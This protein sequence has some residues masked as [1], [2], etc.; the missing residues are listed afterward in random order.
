MTPCRF[1]RLALLALLF[2]LAPARALAQPI[3]PADKARARDLANAGY[4]ALDKKDYAKAAERFAQA[5]GIIRVATVRIG[6][7]R[8]QAGL[9]RLRDAQATYGKIV[10]EGAPPGAPPPIVKAVAEARREVEAL[11]SRIPTLVIRVTGAGE[12]AVTVTMDGLPVQREGLGNKLP[13][14]PGSHTVRATAPGRRP[15]E[16]TLTVTEGRSESVELQLLPEV[17]AAAPVVVAARE[18]WPVR[19]TAGVVLMASSAVGAIAGGALAAAA[20]SKYADLASK[21]P[22]HVG[23]S[24]SLASELASYHAIGAGSLAS[25]VIGGALLG[26]GVILFVTAPK[27]P[28]DTRTGVVV[29]PVVGAGWAGLSG[30]FR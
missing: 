30:T 23:C 4:D 27:A 17:V 3:S 28:Q 20:H 16:M 13:V 26:S 29:S 24:P 14:D 21:C 22:T 8:A 9:G 5:D 1:A 18:P 19:K 6:L 25:F 12:G 2:A 11:G 10:T 7:A 15:I